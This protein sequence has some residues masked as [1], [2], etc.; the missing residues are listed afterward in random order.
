MK[1]EQRK[2]RGYLPDAQPQGRSPRCLHARFSLLV[3]HFA[4]FI[5]HVLRSAVQPAVRYSPMSSAPDML[6]PVTVP[7]KVKFSASPCSS[8]WAL[9]IRTV[10]PAMVPETSRV[11]KSPRC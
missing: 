3:S 4:F 7:E 9:W 6:S 5:L 2:Q 10:S 1:N 11:T 8:P